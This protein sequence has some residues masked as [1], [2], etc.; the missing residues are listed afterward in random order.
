MLVPTGT[1]G[2]IDRRVWLVVAI[3]AQAV[4]DGAAAVNAKMVI[5]ADVGQQLVADDTVQMLQLA[6]G[7]AF[8]VKMMRASPAGH[9]LIDIGRLLVIAE[10]AD[11][12]LLQKH[13]ETTV[14]GAFAFLCSV[15][16]VGVGFGQGGAK[17]VYRVLRIGM[18]RKEGDETGLSLG[19]VGRCHK[20]SFHNKRNRFTV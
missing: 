4:Q 13:G 20:G 17:L 11:G 10:F 8:Q 15:V 3:G 5:C 12:A 16:G 6:A 1:Q 18:L 19:F 2:N 9:I 7:K 14:Q